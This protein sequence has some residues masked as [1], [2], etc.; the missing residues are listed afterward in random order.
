[1]ADF[2]TVRAAQQDLVLSKLSLA[3][4]F[5][6]SSTP[7]ITTVEDPATGDL[8]DLSDY[9]SAGIL[10]KDAGLS[11]T[12]NIDSSDIE[13]YG[14]VEPVRTIIT[15]RTTS[16]NASFIET[17]REVIEKFWGIELD[18]TNLTVSAMGGVTIKAPIRPKNLFYRCVL[19]GQDEVNGLDLFPYW[20]LPKVKLVDVD[21]VDAKDDDAIMYK[22]TFQAFREPEAGFSVIQGWCGAGWQLLVDKTGFVAVPTS[23]NATPATAT[24]APAATQQITVTASNGINR[25]PA[26]T[27]SSSVPAKATVSSAGL[28]TAVATGSS[29]ITVTYDPPTGPPLTDTVAITVS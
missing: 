5:A 26:C 18:G 22:M 25:T 13:G 29:V 17:N 11:I 3:I 8:D 21:N 12:S 6:P 4:L 2:E 10:Q 9:R 15:K 20:I 23:I 14:E 16:F 28:V 1:M 19:L 27:Y 7:V 24:I